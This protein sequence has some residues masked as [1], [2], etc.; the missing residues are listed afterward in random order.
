M[1]KQVGIAAALFLAYGFQVFIRRH[2]YFAV[3]KPE[4]FAH[5]QNFIEREI[6]TVYYE[7]GKLGEVLPKWVDGFKLYRVKEGMK[8]EFDYRTVPDS[9]I[10]AHKLPEDLDDLGPESFFCKRKFDMNRPETI[11]MSQVYTEPGWYASFSRV[12]R[13]A[14]SDLWDTL[15]LPFEVKESEMEH[16]F[17]SNLASPTVTSPVHGAPMVNSM[18]IQFV[19]SKSWLFFPPSVYLSEEGFRA[20]PAASVLVPQ[21]SP[22]PNMKHDL[23]IYTSQ[24]GDV[25]FFQ[26]SWGHLVY[27]HPGP[28]LMINY[29]NLVAQNFFRQPITYFTAIFNHLVFGAAADTNTETNTWPVPEN[30][31][32][33]DMVLKK[34]R[35]ATCPNGVITEF[36]KSMI[37][38][39]HAKLDHL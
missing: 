28:S 39:M 10:L 29:R 20:T 13:Q 8:Y 16:G 35:A 3:I 32:F 15:N 21:K 36:D 26:E 1:F 7:P 2:W 23:Y 27:T 4:D 17:F 9:Q 34:L 24:P 37:E 31:N 14:A 5:K 25:L 11:N 22:N 30:L 18:A 19:G 12:S 33:V 6:E 38:L